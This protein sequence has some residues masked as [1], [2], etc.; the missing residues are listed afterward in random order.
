MCPGSHFATAEMMLAVARVLQARELKKKQTL[1]FEA[2]ITM[3]P[4]GGLAMAAP[5][6]TG[7]YT[8]KSVRPG[9][10]AFADHILRLRK[11]V[12]IDYL[13]WPLTADLEGREVDSFDDE[14]AEYSA[15]VSKGE[16]KAFG[17]LLPTQKKSLLFD[18]YGELVEHN[19]MIERGPALWE[20]TRLAVHPRVSAEEAPKWFKMLVLDSASRKAREGVRYFCSVSDP[21]ME[22]ILRRTGIKMAR[23]GSVHRYENG[24]SVVGLRLDCLGRADDAI[25]VQPGREEADTSEPGLFP[26][27]IH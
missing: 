13:G 14:N 1:E 25:H 27:I 20:G 10:N 23:L 24:V 16:I 9:G 11:E 17:R 18:V 12:F 26:A 6:W 2:L 19:G 8:V 22:R 4:K 21:I 5:S 15:I 3:R 7:L